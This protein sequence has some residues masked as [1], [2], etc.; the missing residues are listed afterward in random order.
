MYSQTTDTIL[1][2]EPVAFGFNTETAV[3]NYFQKNDS[4]APTKL[5]ELALAEFNNMV[6][7]LRKN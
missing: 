1:M 3:N 5:Q 6:D 7:I 4:I 2:I